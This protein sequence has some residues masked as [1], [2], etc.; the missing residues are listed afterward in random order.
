MAIW[1]AQRAPLAGHRVLELGSGGAAGAVLLA[2]A[3]QTNMEPPKGCT[4]DSLK[5]LKRG[6]C[7]FM[8]SWGDGMAPTAVVSIPYCL[9]LILLLFWLLLLLPWRWCSYSHT[10]SH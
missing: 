4:I 8:L 3:R 1:A 10:S 2:S 6:P 7:G 5:I 9:I